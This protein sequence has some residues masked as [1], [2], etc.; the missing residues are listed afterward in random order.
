MSGLWAVCLICLLSP[1]AADA[2]VD[3]SL[4]AIFSVGYAVAG[5]AADVGENRE[6]GWNFYGAIRRE[7]P[8]RLKAGIGFEYGTLGFDAASYF[9]SRDIHT[10]F[11]ENHL[12]GGDMGYFAAVG[13]LF[14]EFPVSGS[15]IPY[16]TGGVGYY[17]WSTDMIILD[18]DAFPILEGESPII[19]ADESGVG[20]KI[21]SGLRFPLGDSP[22]IWGEFALHLVPADGGTLILRP[23]RIGI[24]FP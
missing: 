11:P 23:M 12:E 3:P 18:T 19:F 2:E 9:A 5:G 4:F 16:L 6:T 17:S 1:A 7:I 13:E 20:F 24:S 10:E 15:P 21:G 22:G 8:Y 14:W